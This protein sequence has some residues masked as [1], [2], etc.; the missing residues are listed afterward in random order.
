M[1]VEK[2][3]PGRAEQHI[4]EA[5]AYYN[6]LSDLTPEQRRY[7]SL[8]PEW[9]ATMGTFHATMALLEL[10]LAEDPNRD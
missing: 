9:I 6:Q 3:I 7:K 2:T 4:R 10:K 1:H 5:R 8:T